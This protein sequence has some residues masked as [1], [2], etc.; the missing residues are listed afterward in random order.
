LRQQVSFKSYYITTEK[1]SKMCFSAGA[2]FAS[3]VVLSAIGITTIKEIQKPSQKVF[4]LIPVLFAIQQLSEGC[5]WLTLSGSDFIMVRKICTYIFLITAQVLWSWVIPLSVLLMEEEHKRKKIL[6]IM[7]VIGIALAIYY[8]VYLFFHNVNSRILDCHILY[9]TESPD[10]LAVP[11]FIL[12]LAVTIAPFFVSSIRKMY[13]LGAIMALS[14]LVSA[15]FYKIY[16]TSVWC[17]F[18]AIISIFIYK[19]LRESRKSFANINLTG[20]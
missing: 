13:L 4:A 3:G 2:S 12:Y 8:S 6:R 14:C 11:T 18:A 19:I 9:T 17:F 7:V 5:L 15:V 20:S 16:L 10:S 1:R